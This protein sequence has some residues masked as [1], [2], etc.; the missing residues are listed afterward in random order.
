MP[1]Y[2]LAVVGAGIVGAMHALFAARAG[3]RVA[4]LDRGEWPGGASVRNFGMAIPSGMAAGPWLDL[5]RG[6][7]EIYRELAEAGALSVSGSGSLFLATTDL[8]ARV[9]A[10][11][12]ERAPALGHRCDLLE[13]AQAVAF[14]PA[15]RRD[16]LRAALLFPDDLQVDQRSL[17][18]T[19]IPWLSETL[20]VDWMPG[21]TV[22]G[23]ARRPGGVRVATADGEAVDAARAVVCAGPDLAALF[24]GLAEAASIRRCKLQM[25]RTRPVEELAFPAAVASGWS[26][27]RYDS[28]HACPSHAALLEA[29]IPDDLAALGI[30]LLIKR[31]ADGSV[32]I[33]DSHQYDPDPAAANEAGDP[34]IDAL[35]L[36][37][38]RRLVD[39][40][41]WTVAE[42]W[43]GW[44]PVGNGES[45]VAEPEPGVHV[46]L[47]LGGKGMTC[48]PAFARE[49]V[50]RLA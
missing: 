10:E 43:C 17:P 50:A 34:R 48:A 8:E 28:F 14:H 20:S 46:A 41:D 12:A 36:A 7:V 21:R 40:P 39:L 30:H 5:A 1:W 44:Y 35:I 13:P 29:P 38:A 27:R 22:S 42:R 18:R 19:L 25:L 15:L 31:E 3:M 37:E 4:L 16:G 24:P 6:S 45:L 9:L 49:N 33:G 2:D 26:L 11:F 47:V 23:I 32:T